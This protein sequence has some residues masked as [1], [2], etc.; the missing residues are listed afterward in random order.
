MVK[1]ESP[2]QDCKQYHPPPLKGTPVDVAFDIYCL[3]K[4]GGSG[5]EALGELHP[6]HTRGRFRP[7]AGAP[8]SRGSVCGGRG[9]SAFSHTNCA[10]AELGVSRR[11]PVE[12]LRAPDGHQAV[13]VGELGETPDLV[14]VLEAGPDRHGGKSSGSGAEKAGAAALGAIP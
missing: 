10:R 14:V 9:A 3:E 12:A 7:W 11:S 13:G 5:R 4:F 2:Y 6:G 1:N 8:G